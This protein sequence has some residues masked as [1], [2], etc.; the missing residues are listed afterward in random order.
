M[1]SDGKSYYAQT[2]MLDDIMVIQAMY[3]AETTTRTGNTVYGFNSNADRSVY[4]FSVNKHPVLA[5]WDSGGIDTLDLSGFSTASVI[6]LIPGTFSNCDAM[7]SNI[8]IARNCW[9]ENATGGSGNDTI[10]GNDLANILIGNGGNDTI[11]G[12][13]GNDTLIGGAGADKLQGGDGNDIIYYDATDGM[14][15]VNGGSGLDS[16]AF[17]GVVQAVDLALYGFEQALAIL[18]DT[19]GQSW[20]TKTDVYDLSGNLIRNETQNDNG[21]SSIVEYDVYNQFSWSTRTRSYDSSGTM[22][23]EVLV[24]DS[25]GPGPNLAP[26]DLALSASSVVEGA[27]TGTVVG[28]LSATDPTA[29]DTFTYTLLNN[30]G[31][32]FSLNGAQLVVA[33]A[34]LL[35][36]E[37]ATS[38]AVTVQVKRLGRQHLPGG[39]H[40]RGYQQHRRRYRA[41]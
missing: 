27:A 33:S 2:P 17:L 36:F 13:L 25:G 9:I 10:T 11:T 21:T 37:T 39:F 19:G 7:T 6:S 4:D 22:T 40:D 1:A 8:A 30:A 24:S 28:T 32:R 38:H 5:I 34:A 16:L 29:G 12:G 15:N 3:G 41:L 23:G 26:T 18:T 35:D 20:T 14:A 31:G